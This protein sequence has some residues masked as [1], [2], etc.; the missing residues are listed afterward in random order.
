MDKGDQKSYS[1]GTRSIVR[2]VPSGNYILDQSRESITENSSKKRFRRGILS[3][4]QIVFFLKIVLTLEALKSGKRFQATVAFDAD[5]GWLFQ[6]MY[7]KHFY[8]FKNKN[9]HCYGL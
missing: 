7:A 3:S 4:Y 1:L 9:D 5:T 2:N 8:R 6:M